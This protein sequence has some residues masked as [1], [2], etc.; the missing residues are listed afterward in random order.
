MGKSAPK[1]PDYTAAAEATAESNQEALNMQ[2]W[3]NRMNQ[4][5][6]WGSITYDSESTI[7]PATGQRVTQWTQNQELTPLAQEALDRQM[8]IDAQKSDFASQLMDRAGGTLLQDTDWGK[9]GGYGQAPVA[10][11]MREVQ[12]PEQPIRPPIRPPIDPN[13]GFDDGVRI[14]PDLNFPTPIRPPIRTDVRGSGFYDDPRAG[15]GADIGLPVESLTDNPMVGD[16]PPFSPWAEPETGM[17]S[18][19]A[20]SLR[21]LDDIYARLRGRGGRYERIK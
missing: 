20:G 5:N 14:R 16:T 1:A 3:A 8:A 13:L 10:Y 6:P 18:Y 9:F 4:Y 12:Q 19:K 2:T 17:P 7:D 21:S 11:G 15:G